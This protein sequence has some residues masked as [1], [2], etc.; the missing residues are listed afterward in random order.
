MKIYGDQ[1]LTSGFLSY[2]LGLLQLIYDFKVF[3]CMDVLSTCISVYYIYV[4]ILHAFLCT[5]YMSVYYLYVCVLHACL[6]PTE[7]RRRHHW[8]QEIELRSFGKAG[9][10]LI[11]LANSPVLFTLLQLIAVKIS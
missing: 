1:R 8:A 3:M 2:S 10:P 11:C 4:Y 6:A 5:A 7:A 9:I